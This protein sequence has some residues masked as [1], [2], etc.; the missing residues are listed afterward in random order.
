MNPAAYRKLARL[1]LS[2]LLMLHA[3]DVAA[4]LI[5]CTLCRRQS[6]GAVQ[7]AMLVETEA[8][9]MDEPGC[10][11]YR[12]KTPRN[13]VMF[14]PPG[15]LYV[16]FTYGMWHCCNVVCEQE[17]FAAA[18]LLRA[19]SALDTSA[20]LRLSGPGLLCQGLSIDRGLNGADLLD[21]DEEIWLE[22]PASKG[23]I[24]I[25]WTTRIGFSF[26]DDKLWRCCW[27]GHPHISPA[28]TGV[29]KRKPRAEQADSG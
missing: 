20:N 16:Y 21:P 2:E 9:R 10:H 7:R 26:P 4:G 17:G 18:V 23:Q 24:E 25:S 14:G 22:R 28:R 6:D 3:R 1:P 11:A 27:K 8:Y 5:G 19:A 29:L 12:G 15:H 13:S